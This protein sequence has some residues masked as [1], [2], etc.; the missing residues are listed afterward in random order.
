MR[1]AAKYSVEVSENKSFTSLVFSTDTTNIRAVP[2]SQLPTGRLWWRVRAV[3][4]RGGSSR[5]ATASFSRKAAAGPSLVSPA[6]GATL[7]QPANPPLLRWN[8]VNGAESYEIEIDTAEH[9]W[10]ETETYST[11]TTS[12]VV[13]DPQQPGTYWWRVRAKLDGDILTRPSSTR[14]YVVGALPVVRQASLVDDDPSDSH[15]ED[16]VFDWDPVPGA[17][18]YDIRVST[19][20][21]FNTI[22]DSRAVKGSRYSPTTTYDNT[23]YWWQVRSRDIFGQAEE[24]NTVPIRTFQ[25]AWLD[26]AQLEWPEDRATVAG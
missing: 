26:T 24:W 6:S 11:S 14:S 21:D 23:N 10:V 19:D 7:T 18:S 8:P 15:V 5:W 20:Q 1:G 12:L 13:P 2:Y 16:V 25:R 17:V 4:A 22:V 9:D 3:N